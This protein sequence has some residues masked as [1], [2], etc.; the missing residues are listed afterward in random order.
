MDRDGTLEV[1]QW[2]VPTIAPGDGFRF[3]RVVR[4]VAKYSFVV[5]VLTLVD[6]TFR[7][8]QYIPEWLLPYT[9]TEE[10]I[11]AWLEAELAR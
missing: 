7:E 2:V 10:E 4:R 6:G 3:G 5:D 1:G 11:L 9:P 8:A